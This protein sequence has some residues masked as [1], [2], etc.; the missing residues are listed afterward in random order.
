MLLVLSFL[1][2]TSFVVGHARWPASL[3]SLAVAVRGYSPCVAACPGVTFFFVALVCTCYFL[4]FLRL[5]VKTQHKPLD[6]SNNTQSG[7]VT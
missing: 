4:L 1:F 3:S 6:K 7:R 5:A 2:V